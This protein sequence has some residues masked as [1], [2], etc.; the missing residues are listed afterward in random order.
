MPVG[1]MTNRTVSGDHFI[2]S[3]VLKNKM[4]PMYSFELVWEMYFSELNFW[5]VIKSSIWVYLE[6]HKKGYA[7][8][9]NIH[10]VVG[11]IKISLVEINGHTQ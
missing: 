1:T 6:K 11:G 4:G 10:V 8:L 9:R 5:Q 3:S 2:W 7:W